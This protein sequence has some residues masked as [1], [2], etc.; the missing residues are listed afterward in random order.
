MFVDSPPS[1]VSKNV[2]DFPGMQKVL[3]LDNKYN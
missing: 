3:A 1:I 2:A